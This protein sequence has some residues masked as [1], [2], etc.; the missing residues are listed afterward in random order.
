MSLIV[1]YQGQNYIKL[2]GLQANEMKNIWSRGEDVSLIMVVHFGG[3]SIKIHPYR[4]NQNSKKSAIVTS[5][6][7]FPQYVL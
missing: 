2:Q 5:L 3:K 1:F 6:C 4:Q 7:T